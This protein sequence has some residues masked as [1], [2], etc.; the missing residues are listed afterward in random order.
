MG[1]FAPKG[2]VFVAGR[3]SH[4][5]C[6]SVHA[7]KCAKF[8]LVRLYLSFRA[9]SVQNFKLYEDIWN[10]KLFSIQNRAKFQLIR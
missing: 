6:P 4:R 1:A 7:L 2:S 9:E 5:T 3:V 10:K 8:Q